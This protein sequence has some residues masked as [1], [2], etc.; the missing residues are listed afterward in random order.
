MQERKN[1]QERIKEYQ[2]QAEKRR[3]KRRK[4]VCRL[5]TE[6]WRDFDGLQAAI[7]Q[8][9]SSILKLAHNLHEIE[10]AAALIRRYEQLEYEAKLLGTEVPIGKPQLPKEIVEAY[11]SIKGKNPMVGNR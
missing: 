2:R 7:G 11:I 4:E 1:I 9:F 8:E 5:M 10:K 6:L 3:A